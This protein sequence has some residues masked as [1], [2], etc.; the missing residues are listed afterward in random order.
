LLVPGLGDVAVDLA[1]VDGLDE[2]VG[3]GVGGEDDPD[4]IG[5]Q[6]ARF[7]HEL[8]P[9]HLGHALIA[10]DHRDVVLFEQPQRLVPRY[11]AVRIWKDALEVEAEGVEVV[12]LVIDDEDREASKIGS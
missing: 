9:G 4:G 11:P 1:E 8:E 2:D 12:A 5:A 7:A 6:R 10:H 3:V